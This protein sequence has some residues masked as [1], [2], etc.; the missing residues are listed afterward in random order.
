MRFFGQE[1]ETPRK[2]RRVAHCPAEVTAGR[3]LSNMRALATRA[4]RLWTALAL[5]AVFAL[6]FAG[7]VAA[8]DDNL[9]LASERESAESPA[10][11]PSSAPD[12]SGRVNGPTRAQFKSTR[13]K[14]PDAGS[15]CS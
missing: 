7:A 15:A 1:E 8:Q 5:L 12:A 13:S 10:A 14:L 6:P 9:D 2:A 3:R 4:L 11:I